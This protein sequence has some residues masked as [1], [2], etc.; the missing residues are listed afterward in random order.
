MSQPLTSLKSSKEKFKWTDAEHNVFDEVKTIVAHNRRIT[1]TQ[2]GYTITGNKLLIIIE[3]LKEVCNI[4]L[5]QRLK[6]YTDHRNINSKSL[7]YI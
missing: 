1:R 5:G 3:N 4:L 7:I 2:T 6:I